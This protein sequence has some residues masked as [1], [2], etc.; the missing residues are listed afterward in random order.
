VTERAEENTVVPD[1]AQL[2][3]RLKERIYAA[4]TIIAV[5]LGLALS[6]E[7][8]HL[9]VTLSVI[10]TSLGLWLAT[11]AAEE[12]SHR[13]VHGHLMDAAELR[14]MLFVSSP[15]LTAAVG[16]LVLVGLSALGALPLTAAL[17]VSVGVDTASLFVWGCVSGRR[18][19]ATL[20]A[21]VCVGLIDLLIGGIVIGIK[22]A[23]G[24]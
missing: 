6:G 1:V 9:A 21:A 22:L 23:A 12:Q 14:H 10:G 13:I 15:L 11:I 18:M 7:A 8:T 20:V 17:Y 2:A 24:H 16:P 4:L 19:G 3:D 5:A